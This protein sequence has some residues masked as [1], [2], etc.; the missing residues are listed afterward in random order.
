MFHSLD[1]DGA[2]SFTACKPVFGALPFGLNK[3]QLLMHWPIAALARSS[4]R[5]RMPT[6]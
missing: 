6:P 5:R 1:L 3:H 2:S 4:W